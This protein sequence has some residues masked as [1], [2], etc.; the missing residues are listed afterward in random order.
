MK[1][2]ALIA[3]NHSHQ[4]PDH[5]KGRADLFGS[6]LAQLAH[7]HG[8]D[9]IAEEMSREALEM[10]NATKSTVEA[11]AESLQIRHLLCDPDSAER[12]A[13][14]IPSYEDLKVARGI[15]HVFEAEEALLKADERA[16]WPIRETEWL[17]RLGKFP[18]RSVLFVL[19]PDHVD[20]FSTLLRYVDYQVHVVNRRWTP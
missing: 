4:Y 15:R 8:V 2:I 11:V 16:Y 13:L 17:N 1:S 10:E 19:G 5:P 3:A 12:K 20:T 14:G 6:L 9:L 18:H 7:S